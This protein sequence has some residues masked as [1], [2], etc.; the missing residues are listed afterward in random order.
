[1]AGTGETGRPGRFESDQPAVHG[2]V[3]DRVCRIVALDHDGPEEF[4][5]FGE[6]E[7]GRSICL[8]VGPWRHDPDPAVSKIDADVMADLFRLGSG[9]AGEPPCLLGGIG[10]DHDDLPDALA[11]VGVLQ[12]PR[13]P[14]Q[15]RCQM[16]A[17]VHPSS[18]EWR[19]LQADRSESGLLGGAVD[20]DRAGELQDISRLQVE[21][22]QGLARGV[23]V[24]GS[25]HY[26]VY[27][28]P[29]FADLGA[30]VG[31]LGRHPDQFQIA[32]PKHC[33]VIHGSERVKRSGGQGE[34]EAPE[35]R[36]QLVELGLRV[37]D[38]VIDVHGHI[39]S[40]S[41][42]SGRRT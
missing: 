37:E 23:G 10:R 15:L 20:L 4:R 25:K 42:S 7:R 6:R 30:S 14:N 8:L 18:G 13:L 32:L 34:S 29:R 12:H 5:W 27:S 16:L 3:A 40:V 17:E 38:D 39:R 31:S 11:L 21:A 22:K 1:M 2:G 24:L 33:H 26:A 36:L 35:H 41:T 9:K 28:G 19:A